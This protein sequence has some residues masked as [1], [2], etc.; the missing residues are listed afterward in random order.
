MR[1]QHPVKISN[2]KTCTN[3]TVAVVSDVHLGHPNTTTEEIIHG[4]DHAFADTP[5]FAS[6]DMIFFGGDLFD[7]DLMV[8]QPDIE[9]IFDWWHR[10]LVRCKKHQIKIRVLEGTPSHDFKQFKVF[11]RINHT[12]KINAD[13]KYYE[14]LTIETEHD[15]GLT[16]LYLPDE[17]N[18]SC[19]DTEIEIREL[20]NARGIEQ[21]DLV[22]MHGQFAH[23]FPEH[24]ASRIDCHNA[25]FYLSIC[26]QFISAG[27]VHQ[28]S[29]YKRIVAQGSFDRLC[30]GNEEAKGYI[31]MELD[32]DNPKKSKCT[33]IENH[34]AKSYVTF[35]VQ[36]DTSLD[37]AN[38][39]IH[40]LA[41]SLA[42]GSYLRILGNAEHPIFEVLKDI[43]EFYP[44]LNWSVK[45]ITNTQKDALIAQESALM[46]IRHRVSITK[47]NLRELIKQRL[48]A[49]DDLGYIM[50]ILTHVG[51]S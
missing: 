12:S 27:H 36:D 30:H 50:E 13:C 25:D 20:L 14:T 35:K 1:V 44:N 3:L 28:F 31:R 49:N 5:A 7:R 24:V 33:F 34:L 9:M 15:L 18:A 37:R 10:F 22:I 40:K 46:D 45:R 8:P 6:L 43:K 2:T 11:G 48:Q 26:K 17:Y 38:L 16:V 19:I 21:V 4:L 32:L 29:Q 39:E 47:D 41:S 42:N 23:Q 51:V